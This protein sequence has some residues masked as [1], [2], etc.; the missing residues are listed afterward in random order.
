MNHGIAVGVPIPARSGRPIL[1][2]VGPV[3]TAASPLAPPPDEVADVVRCVPALAAFFQ[4]ARSDVSPA[5]QAAFDEHHLGPR[6]AAVLIQLSAGPP[7]GVAAL[8]E[9]IGSAVPTISELV[10]D[11]QRAGMVERHEDPDDRRRTL[12]SLPD[13]LR[14]EYDQFLALRAEPLLRALRDLPPE[15]REGFVAGLRLWVGEIGPPDER[16]ARAGRRRQRAL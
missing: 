7:L 16:P 10:G 4:R 1:R 12:V 8:A 6:H 15:Q 2:R 5:L 13:R 9:R 3:P 14:E 11:L